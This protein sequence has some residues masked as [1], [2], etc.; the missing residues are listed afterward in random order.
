M[1]QHLRAAG[2][3][4]AKSSVDST[5]VDVLASLRRIEEL[6]TLSVNMMREEVSFSIAFP[7]RISADSMR[8]AWFGHSGSTFG[9]GWRI[10]VPL[11]SAKA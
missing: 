6:L 8:I 4:P 10:G 2:K 1:E 7:L 5:S 9:R 3:K 11:L